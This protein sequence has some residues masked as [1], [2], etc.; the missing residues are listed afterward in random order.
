MPGIGE[1]DTR[2]A[3]MDKR[4]VIKVVRQYKK[5]VID[6]MGPVTV[7]LFGSYS[8]G[9]PNPESDIDVA[10]I[11]PKVNGDFLAESARLWRITMNVNTLIEPVLIEECNPSP[12]YQE[13]LRTGVA[14]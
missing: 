5:A 12:L 2:I 8:N 6:Q 4:Q 14:V 11:V 7:Y 13:I 3:E 1:Q 9:H 10:V